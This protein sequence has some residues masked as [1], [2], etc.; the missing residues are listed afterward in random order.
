MSEKKGSSETDLFFVIEG[1][2]TFIEKMVD[3]VLDDPTKMYFKAE[4]AKFKDILTSPEF[5]A[6]ACFSYSNSLKFVK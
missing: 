5:S 1:V 6:C 2:M 4:Y 3:A